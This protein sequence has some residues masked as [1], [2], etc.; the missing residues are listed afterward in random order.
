MKCD[1]C[2][3]EETWIEMIGSNFICRKCVNKHKIMGLILRTHINTFQ[4]VIKKLKVKN[5]DEFMKISRKQLEEIIDFKRI[6]IKLETT[7]V[8]ELD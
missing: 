3:K 2:G 7:N 6:G 4:F 5:Y 1:N 8:V